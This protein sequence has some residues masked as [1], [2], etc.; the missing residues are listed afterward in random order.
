MG[1]IHEVARMSPARLSGAARS[2]QV[3][4]RRRPRS[5]LLLRL[6]LGARYAEPDVQRLGPAPVPAASHGGGPKIIKACRNP[7]MPLAR[8]DAV[9]RID[10]D[11]S[12]LRHLHLGPGMPS[13]LAGDTVRPMKI[14]GNVSGRKR[15]ASRG[16]D[17]DVGE[18]LTNPAT[19]REGLCRRGG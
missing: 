1:S 19:H 5:F 15:A 12:E 17:E 13:L 7:H 3:S 6:S 8:R 18:I 11:P 10:P 9:G 16:G 2:G 4:S 14:T